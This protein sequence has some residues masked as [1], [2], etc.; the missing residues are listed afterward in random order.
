M[1]VQFPDKVIGPEVLL[2]IGKLEDHPTGS[3]CCGQLR[4]M[5]PHHW[6]DSWQQ[7]LLTLE[8]TIASGVI[9]MIKSQLSV[10]PIGSMF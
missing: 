3:C 1:L 4:N 5:I 9:K 7:S 6:T 10:D 2:N 8:F